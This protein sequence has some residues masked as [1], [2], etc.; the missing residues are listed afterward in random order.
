MEEVVIAS[1]WGWGGE[2]SYCL[3][4][5]VSVW[6]YEKSSGNGCGDDCTTV[7]MYLI[8]L[9]CTLKNYDH[10]KFHVTWILPQ[11]GKN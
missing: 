9:S 7:W 3:L 5:T 4:A 1:G 10:G 11:C 8:P 2:E 6:D